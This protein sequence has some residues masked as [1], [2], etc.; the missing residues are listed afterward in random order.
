MITVAEPAVVR[1][2]RTVPAIIAALSI[3]IPETGVGRPNGPE[4]TGA[5]NPEQGL[6]LKGREVVRLAMRSTMCPG[7]KVGLSTVLRSFRQKE[8]HGSRI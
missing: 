1:R 2:S 4:M 7:M 3:A 6:S 8:K 5:V